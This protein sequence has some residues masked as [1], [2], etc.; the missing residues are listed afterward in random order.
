MAPG[1]PLVV[2]HSWV[3]A[4]LSVDRQGEL[5][6]AVR[7]L[8]RRRRVHYLYAESP[9]E[10]PGLPTPPSPQPR[11]TSH[12]ATALVHVDLDPGTAHSHEPV[13]L[14]DMHPHGTW[15]SWWGSS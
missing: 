14:A 8:A 5:V 3:A 11:P 12:L 10:T 13:R 15:L 2:F 7:D 6:E 1:Q 9:V 4:Y